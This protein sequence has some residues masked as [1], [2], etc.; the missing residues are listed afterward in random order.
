V[1]IHIAPVTEL[2]RFFGDSQEYGEP[3]L[4]VATAILTHQG[5]EV[6]IEGAHA[7]GFTMEH[8]KLLCDAYRERGVERMQWMHNGKQMSEELKV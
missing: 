1:K 2:I 4:G 8:Y 6:Y 5:K 7:G 3:Y